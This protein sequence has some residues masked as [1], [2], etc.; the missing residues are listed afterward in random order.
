ME[1]PNHLGE[2]LIA[3]VKIVALSNNISLRQIEQIAAAVTFASSEAL[4]DINTQSIYY[5]RNQIPLG[6]HG[7][8]IDLIISRVVSPNLHPKFLNATITP[9]ELHS[10]FGKLGYLQGYGRNEKSFREWRYLSWLCITQNVLFTA[11]DIPDSE[12]IKRD[13]FLYNFCREEN[14][15]ELPQIIQRRWLDLFQFN[16]ST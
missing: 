13:L 5:A 9:D 4:E 16:E 3:Q 14:S 11:G 12:N 15:R 6:C 8:M 1:I 7:V 2:A 10:Y